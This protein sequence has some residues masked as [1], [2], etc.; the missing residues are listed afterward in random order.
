MFGKKRMSSTDKFI[1]AQGKMR[2]N[3]GNTFA[4][5]PAQTG[6]ARG[7]FKAISKP[8]TVPDSG[9]KMMVKMDSGPGLTAGKNRPQ[10]PGKTGTFNTNP[11]KKKALPVGGNVK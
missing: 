2:G 6:K 11:A 5:A 9:R 8:A 1:M 7:N 4:N 3:L 10:S